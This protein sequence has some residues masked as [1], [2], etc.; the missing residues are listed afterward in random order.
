MTQIYDEVAKRWR[1]L[2]PNITDSDFETETGYEG[3]R[4]VRQNR[5]EGHY[6]P[7]EDIESDFVTCNEFV[8]DCTSGTS[9]DN[10]SRDGLRLDFNLSNS[11][12]VIQCIHRVLGKNWVS[13]NFNLES[14]ESIEVIKNGWNSFLL[15]TETGTEIKS[16]NVVLASL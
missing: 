10:I 12:P 2:P 4:T 1:L 3:L 11:R 6:N 15:C 5:P 13:R 16:N 9:E 8:A 7:N 14:L